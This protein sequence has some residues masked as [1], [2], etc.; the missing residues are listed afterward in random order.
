M[1][2]HIVSPQLFAMVNGT[3]VELLGVIVVLAV[4]TSIGVQLFGGK[5]DAAVLLVM[6]SSERKIALRVCTWLMD[7]DSTSSYSSCSE[8]KTSDDGAPYR[9]TASE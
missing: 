8:T 1:P 6:I 4:V 2:G 5:A 7:C 9:A 3:A